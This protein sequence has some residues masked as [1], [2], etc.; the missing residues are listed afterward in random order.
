VSVL[1][2]F[3]VIGK[4]DLETLTYKKSSL[5]SKKNDQWYSDEPVRNRKECIKPLYFS[6]FAGITKKS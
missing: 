1:R 3:V 2:N 4:G 5:L 6:I